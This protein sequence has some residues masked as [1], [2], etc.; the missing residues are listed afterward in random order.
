MN[1]P[2]WHKSS[3]SGSNGGECVEVGSH[4]GRVLVRDTRDQHTVQYCSSARPRGASSPTA[5]RTCGCYSRSVRHWP[6]L[7]RGAFLPG[8]PCTGSRSAGHA[9]S[10]WTRR[11][12]AG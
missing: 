5:S 6:T 3:Y 2:T 11:A 12:G 1:N 7:A 10:S 9:A 4:H 8:R